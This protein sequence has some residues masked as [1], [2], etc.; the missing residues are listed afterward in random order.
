MCPG[1]DGKLRRTRG[2]GALLCVWKGKESYLERLTVADRDWD[3]QDGKREL[4]VFGGLVGKG[5]Y[6]GSNGGGTG[7]TCALVGMGN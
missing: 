1:G 6:L 2:E 4:Y 5:S 3:V 7:V